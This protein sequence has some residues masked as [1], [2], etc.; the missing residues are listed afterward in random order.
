M[1]TRVFQTDGWTAQ[2][3]AS[4]YE[5]TWNKR[6]AEYVRAQGERVKMRCTEGQGQLEKGPY[7]SQGVWTHPEGM[8]GGAGV[9]LLKIFL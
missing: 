5:K 1:K 2:A 4:R 7:L 8:G 9:V 3:K 6:T